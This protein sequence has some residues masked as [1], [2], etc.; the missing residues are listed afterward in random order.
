MDPTTTLAARLASSAVAPLVRKLFVRG[1]PGAALVERPVRI[2]GLVSFRGERRTLDERGLRALAAELVA[3]A[4][5]A[6]GPHEAPD[7]EVRRELTDALTA[8]LHS[9]GDLDMDDVQAVRLGP[10]ALAAALARPRHLS[11]AA[12]ARYDP[13]LHT[14]CLHI[15]TFFTQRSTFVA[16]TLT[17]QTRLLDQLVA[18]TDL[19]LERIPRQP[20]EDARFERRYAEH[21]AR[22][23]SELTIYGLDLNHAREWCLDSAYVSLEATHQRPAPLPADESRPNIP[24]DQSTLPAEQ[25]LS[26]RDRVLLRGGAGSGKTTLVQWLA[27]TTARQE[28]AELTDQLTP[29]IG[30]VPFV[31]PLRR[32]IRDGAPPTPDAFL[33]TVRSAVAGAQPDGWADRVLR[34]GRALLLIDGI[35]EIP[36]RERDET[37]RWLRE[38][39]AEFPGNLWLVTARPSA[40]E[41][42]WLAAEGFHELTLAPMS[43]QDVTHFVARWHRAAD[44]DPAL[45]TAL[46]DAVRTSSDLGR[47]ADNPLM[48][49]LLCALHRERRGFLPHGRKDLYEA[50]LRMLLE[51]RDVERG[52]WGEPDLRLSS[53]TQILL[54]QKLAHWLIRNDRAEMERA[55]ALTQIERALVSMAHVTAAPDRVLRHLLERSG[56]VREPAVGRVDFVHRTFQ[57]YLGAKAIV[58]E[59][60]FPLLLDH[61]HHDQWEDVVRMA[62]ALGRPAERE[63]ILAGLVGGVDATDLACLMNQG[64]DPVIPAAHQRQLRG[65]LLAA[66]CLEHATE[67]AP[68]TRRRVLDLLAPLVP[69]RDKHFAITL[70]DFGGPRV[71]GLLPGPDGLSRDQ[72]LNVVITAVHIGGDA[73]LAL[74]TRFRH[75]PDLMVRRQLAWSWHRFD[76]RPYAAEI[77]AHLDI[78][79]LYFTAHNAEHLRV[80]REMGRYNRLQVGRAQRGRGC[81]PEDLIAHADP[82]RLTHLWLRHSMITRPLEWLS[83]FPRLT[84]LVLPEG[85]LLERLRVPEGITVVH[86]A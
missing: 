34:A 80:L 81:T 67:I 22:K 57:D 77:L 41:E 63:R 70:G 14:A 68:G 18:T 35:D 56:L 17:E 71:L 16:R 78:R 48:C 44:A 47:L 1:E 74:L 40:V 52:V 27:V 20:A 6:L 83:A 45:V 64:V 2:G 82:E 50:A 36:R 62:V 75:H 84:V 72:A 5:A 76:T 24:A 69:P 13:L 46:L 43:R 53:E 9:L 32:V 42:H 26:G 59:G 65:V 33:H 30:R 15:L 23:H 7:P 51:R 61:A 19:L 3:R 58:E 10:G 60:D 28:Y 29:L 12:E 66:S 8:A 39:L 55:D 4:A 31:L 11:A 54:L 86:S 85:Y 38:L 73:A 49:G 79:D 25:V 37:R 21:I